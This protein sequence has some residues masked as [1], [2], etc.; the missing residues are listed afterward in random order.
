MV[1]LSATIEP[2]QTSRSLFV[3]SQEG[4]RYALEQLFTLQ[5]PKVFRWAVLLGLSPAEAEDAAQEALAI[6]ARRLGNCQAEAALTT[7]LYQILRR[8]VANSRRTAWVRRLFRPAPDALEPAFEADSPADTEA[9]LAVRTCF[10]RLSP[11]LAEVLLLH[12]V[13]GYTRPEIS[14]ILGLPEGTVASRLRLAKDAFRK[15]WDETPTPRREGERGS[16]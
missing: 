5:A 9:E 15:H 11:A 8:V 10:Q 13:E 2:A 3:R 6:A 7:W 14:Q 16:P 1:G 12:E 4:D